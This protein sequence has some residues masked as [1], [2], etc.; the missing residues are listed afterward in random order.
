MK[1]YKTYI[2]GFDQ[3]IEGGIPEGHVVLISGPP[4]TMKSSVAYSMLYNNARFNGT[5]G[6]YVC[7]EQSKKSLGFHMARLGMKDEKVEGAIEILDLSKIRKA[8]TENVQ[9]PW[10]EIMKKHLADVKHEKSFE[11]IVI[12]SL[13]VLE[14][15]A[16]L[17]VKRSNLFHFFEWLRDLGVTSLVVSEIIPESAKLYDED[18]L[19]DGVIH[20]LMEKVGK[21]DV[22]R[23][24]RCVKLRGVK[25]STGYFTLE[26]RNG[27]FHA[28]QVI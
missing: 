7:L 15:M 2:E 9:R 26:F 13:P 5:K 25:H 28:T 23:R 11:L 12:D 19:A 18:F 21:I 8:M 27:R 22:Y 16:A 20:L 10:L 14:M 4:G 24:I 6:L 17:R 3:E 1:T